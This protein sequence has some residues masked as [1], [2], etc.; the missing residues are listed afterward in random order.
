[1]S[2]KKTDLEKNKMLKHDI[3]LRG[4]KTP[5]R[6]G[7]ASALSDRKAQRKADQAAGLVPFA[8][9]LPMSLIERLRAAA[10]KD[11]LTLNEATAQALERGLTA[12]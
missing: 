6:F 4:A 2:M 8:V 5:D 3:A 11:G 10:E 1:M 12:D 9:K 7:T